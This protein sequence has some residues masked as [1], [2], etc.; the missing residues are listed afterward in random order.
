MTDKPHIST[1]ERRA[2]FNRIKA[3]R[4]FGWT[5]ERAQA[6]APLRI[7]LEMSA[8]ARRRRYALPVQ[9]RLL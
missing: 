3:L 5:F 8:L 7:A 6:W 1:D 4:F 9:P 2:A